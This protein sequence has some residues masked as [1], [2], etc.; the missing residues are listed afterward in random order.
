MGKCD[1]GRYQSPH[2]EAQWLKR[3]C[4]QAKP[5][6]SLEQSLMAR[7]QVGGGCR[8]WCMVETVQH[9]PGVGMIE[10]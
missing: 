9:T 3:N 7:G 1:A 4:T 6:V 5:P 10:S 2:S 8:V